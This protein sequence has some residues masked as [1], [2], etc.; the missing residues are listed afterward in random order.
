MLSYIF[1][2]MVGV[3]VVFSLIFGS[4]DDLS[5]SI[6]EGC[7]DAVELIITMSAMMCLW[8][9]VMNVAKVSGLTEKI[10]KLCAPILSFIFKDVDKNSKAFSYISMNVSANLLGLGNA[11][12]VLG[13]KAMKEL[14]QDVRGNVASDSM[15]TFVVLNTAS[16][17]LLPTTIAAMRASYGSDSPFDII[18]C[19]WFTSIIALMV[20]LSVNKIFMKTGS[21]KWN[22]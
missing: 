3:S 14:A 2:F 21:K 11:A 18:F 15:V 22:M 12:T 19:V 7:G 5:R 8:S 10:S 9:G 4:G 17:Q 16:L 13:I 1:T 20:G 6:T